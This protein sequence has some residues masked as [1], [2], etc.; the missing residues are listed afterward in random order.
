METSTFARRARENSGI[1]LR[2][3]RTTYPD[4]EEVLA[5]DGARRAVEDL[6]G[7]TVS[8]AD[9]V[10]PGCSVAGSSDIDTRSITVVRASTGRMQFTVLHEVAHVLG[11]DDFDFQ[12]ALHRASAVSRRAVEED[13]C[14][15][16]AAT[17]L[18]PEHLVDEVVDGVGVTARGLQELI[19]LRVASREA[20]AVGLAHRMVAPGYV[21]II[22]ADGILQFAARSGDVLPLARGSQQSQS[23]VGELGMT[24]EQFRGWGALAYASGAPTPELHFDLRRHGD[25]VLVVATT[26]NPG[27]GALSVSP[28]KSAY[29]A[30]WCEQCR[31]EFG[32]G[33][34]CAACGDPVHRDCGTCLCEVR[35]RTPN[36]LCSECFLVHPVIQYLA[37][38]TICAECRS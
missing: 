1:L 12:E 25:V 9:S 15:A 5:R 36:R 35:V 16:F 29:A 28:A 8:I 31:V 24:R 18:L 34:L 3:V 6:L 7:I 38:G 11:D 33:R 22:R 10:Q 4:L 14:E 32:V 27:W 21:A 37:D 23:I 26:D 2:A 20:C 13:A 17:L 30:A 19:D